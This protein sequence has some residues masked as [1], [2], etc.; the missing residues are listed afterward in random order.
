MLFEKGK[1]HNQQCEMKIF[2][3]Q[4]TV[5]SQSSLALMYILSI[6]LCTGP[7]VMQQLILIVNLTCVAFN[8]TS[9][10]ERVVNAD[11][12]YRLQSHP[13]I[14]HT[15]VKLNNSHC[16]QAG[17]VREMPKVL[18]KYSLLPTYFFTDFG[19]WVGVDPAHQ[20][21]TPALSAVDPLM[22]TFYLRSICNIIIIICDEM[23]ILDAE[24]MSCQYSQR[25]LSVTD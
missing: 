20:P 22:V 16:S 8:F 5:S 3:F 25:T 12:F 23:K 4:R 11:Q 6:I 1:A 24:K 15:V 19:I 2:D 14:I 21:H 13:S 18:I 17:K 7:F 9:A 10:A